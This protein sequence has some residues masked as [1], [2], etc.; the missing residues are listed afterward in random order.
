MTETNTQY[1]TKALPPR[2]AQG[3]G[4]MPVGT[5][6]E[7]QLA[8]KTYQEVIVEL[9]DD[10]DY[11]TIEGKKHRKR[12]GWTKIRRFYGINTEILH[13]ERWTQ[14]ETYGYRV[15]VRA[16]VTDAYGVTRRQEV[17]DGACDSSEFKTGRLKATDHNVRSKAVT[18]AKNR[19]TSDIVGAGEVSAEEFIEGQ[20]T[21]QAQPAKPA[22]KAAAAKSQP[23]PSAPSATPQAEAPDP[24]APARTAPEVK[25]AIVKAVSAYRAQLGADAERAASNGRRGA[26]VGMLGKACQ[27]DAAKRHSIT[28]YLVGK[29]HIAELSNAEAQAMIDWTK[30][31]GDNNWTLRPNALSEAAACVVA[32][33]VAQGQQEMTIESEQSE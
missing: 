32:W 15:T 14:G 28:M 8:W 10:S 26:A 21:E 3:S 11:A 33:N 31:P 13:E 17:S 25:A 7:M 20:T 16:S 12:S 24:K 19:A 2:E 22:P 30:Q 18:R 4:L 1:Q 5:L 23:A 27:D 9:L 29:A 6:A